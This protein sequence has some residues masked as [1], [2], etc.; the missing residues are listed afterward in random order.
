MTD[1]DEHQILPGITLSKTGQATVD[2]TATK[3]LI[4]LAIEIDDRSRHPVDVEH[5]LAAIIMASR[6]G[7]LP[8]S[9]DLAHANSELK[10]CLAQY[11]E[12]VFEK[13]GGNV[14]KDD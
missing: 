9:T 5:V 1:E 13:F 14:S 8:E 11:V 2:P 6:E 7:V 3:N 4:D 10:T 12:L